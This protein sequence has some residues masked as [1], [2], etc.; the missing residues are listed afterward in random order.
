MTSAYIGYTG[1]PHRIWAS[2]ACY[3]ATSD[4][5][6]ELCARFLLV[7]DHSPPPISL[8]S[9]ALCPQWHIINVSVHTF[10][11]LI[12]SLLYHQYHDKLLEHMLCIVP[13]GPYA[14]FTCN[15]ISK[16]FHTYTHM[17]STLHNHKPHSHSATETRSRN[18]AYVYAPHTSAV[19]AR[20]W[21]ADLGLVERVNH[22]V[23]QLRFQ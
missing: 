12:L 15:C 2:C 13:M 6:W 23:T 14:Q 3:W 1:K 17:H 11:S 4:R 21:E 20:G 7:G 8:P 22:S 9:T 19:L 18:W 10:L 5:L 16:H